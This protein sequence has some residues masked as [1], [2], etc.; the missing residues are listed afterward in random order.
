MALNDLALVTLIQA[1]N[2]LR[3]DAAAS[4]HIAAEYVGVGAPP[5]V[6]FPLD[7]TPVEGSLQLYVDGT[8]QV[9]D[10]DFTISGATITFTTAPGSGLA[11]TASYDTAAGANTF[12]SYD[13]DLLENLIEAGITR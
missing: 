4:L 9:E 3:I 12:E 11:I 7:N 1:K 6:E 8:L 5:A 13:D 10:T 2:H